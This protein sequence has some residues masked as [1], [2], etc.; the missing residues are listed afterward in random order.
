MIHQEWIEDEFCKINFGDCRLDK[1]LISLTSKFFLGS[2]GSIPS[3]YSGWTA[4]KA[5][6]RFFK[7]LKVNYKKIMKAHRDR[8]I[9]RISDDQTILL[10]Q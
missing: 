8:S 4:T 10:I 9:E 6:Y 7:N 1:R 3:A 5:C 2:K